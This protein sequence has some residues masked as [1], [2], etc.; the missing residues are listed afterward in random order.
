MFINYNYVI[1]FTYFNDCKENVELEFN[2]ISL[3]TKK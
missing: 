1:K 3:Y 2:V